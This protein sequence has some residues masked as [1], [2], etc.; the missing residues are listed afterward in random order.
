VGPD[1]SGLS[2]DQER[3]CF[4]F[5]QSRTAGQLPGFFESSFWRQLVLRAAHHET[6]IKHAVLALG[7]LHKRFE[8]GDKSVLHTIWSKGEGG[9]ALTQY[10]L[11]I[12]QLVKPA[13]SGQRAIDVCL[14][15]CVLFSCFEVS[16]RQ[17]ER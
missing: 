17:H 3:R 11:A 8:D 2:D 7:S 12:Q 14:I 13:D 4:D 1:L 15:A 6:A 5:F 9:F 10:N 16:H